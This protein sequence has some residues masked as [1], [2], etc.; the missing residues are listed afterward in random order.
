MHGPIKSTLALTFS[1][2]HSMVSGEY[3]RRRSSETHSNIEFVQTAGDVHI[4]I[5]ENVY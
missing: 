3:D 5:K 2:R 4:F 1:E